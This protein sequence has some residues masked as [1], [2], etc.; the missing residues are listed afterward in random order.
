MKRNE[1]RIWYD[2][3]YSDGTQDKR[4]ES[5]VPKLIWIGI[6]T[7]LLV[8][9][10][11]WIIAFVVIYAGFEIQAWYDLQKHHEPNPP[12]IWE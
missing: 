8:F 7:T 6:L 2:K 3:G 5:T 10:Q 4:K 11:Y 12:E 9:D 1:N